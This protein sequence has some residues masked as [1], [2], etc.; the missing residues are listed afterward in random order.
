[1]DN[2]YPWKKWL[3]TERGNIWAT[4]LK[5]A[6]Y[7]VS[8]GDRWD[9]D[10]IMSNRVLN[11]AGA[12]NTHIRD[13][14]QIKECF[15]EIEIKNN[16]NIDYIVNKYVLRNRFDTSETVATVANNSMANQTIMNQ[17]ATGACSP[18][19]FANASGNWPPNLTLYDLA[20]VTAHYKF[21]RKQFTLK[22][23]RVIKLQLH[24]DRLENK[25][26]NTAVLYGNEKI[27]KQGRTK[28]LFLT[29]QGC[30][31]HEAGL[32]PA[33]TGFTVRSEVEGLDIEQIFH[34]CARM[35]KEPVDLGNITKYD[36]PTIA[37]LVSTNITVPNGAYNTT[38]RNYP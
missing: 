33:D 15:V 31:G 9:F 13:G 4:Q 8:I 11:Y 5:G 25:V 24:P 12:V 37:D 16:S 2:L 7:N 14:L 34:Y 26:F 32:I 1:M 36:N 3:N 6:T 35:V 20:E 19:N 30:M 10:A 22:A 28:H 29:F 38:A 18:S 27:F 17:G 23:G 21:S